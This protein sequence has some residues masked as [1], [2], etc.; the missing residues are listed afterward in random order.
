MAMKARHHWSHLA[1]CALDS[2]RSH[3]LPWD[4]LCVSNLV[5]FLAASLQPTEAYYA[6]IFCLITRPPF[7]FRIPLSIFSHNYSF[8]H[9]DSTKGASKTGVVSIP[10]LTIWYTQWLLFSPQ[11]SWPL[12]NTA[13]HSLYSD[14][15]PPFPATPYTFIDSFRFCLQAFILCPFLQHWD[16]TLLLL[17]IHSLKT[18]HLFHGFIYHLQPEV[19]HIFISQSVVS[20]DFQIHILSCQLDKYAWVPNRHLKLLVQN[21]IIF[22]TYP[23]ISMSYFSE[24]HHHQPNHPRKKTGSPSSSASVPPGPVNPFLSFKSV[25]F[26]PFS[27]P[28]F[29]HS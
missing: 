27:L 24:K 1:T 28:Q 7:Y 12:S 26:M 16:F 4:A 3:P 17:H 11:F 19:A 25:L 23:A 29:G 14:P 9:A 18:S 15:L 22:S 5:S 13:D 10:I 6:L 8:T 21:R 20:L 2:F